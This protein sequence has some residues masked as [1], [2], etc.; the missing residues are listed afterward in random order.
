ML[1]NL[2]FMDGRLVPLRQ[3]KLSPLNTAL[4]YGESLFEAVPVYHGKPL[5]FQEHLERLEKGCHFLD[6]PM[7]SRNQFERA[8]RLFA[9]HAPVHFIIRFSLVQEMDPPAGP[10]QFSKKPP[11]LLAM[12]RPLRHS[13]EDFY[14]SS[15]RAGVATSAVPT[16]SA[17]PGQFKWIFYMMVRR[18]FRLHPEWDEMLRLGDKGFV[19]DGGSASPLWAVEGKV[20]APPLR[21]GGL[22]SV[23][24]RTILELCRSIGIPVVEKKWRP[25]DVLKKG[26]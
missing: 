25:S 9:A 15:G 22:E 20:F 14:P 17:V 3:A 2:I 16:P 23:T 19:V 7:P 11:R 12:I 21:E 24:R 1:S 13:P 6:W 8:I 26:E 4:L 10:R 5:H 18:D